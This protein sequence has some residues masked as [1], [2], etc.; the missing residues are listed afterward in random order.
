MAKI[1]KVFFRA[2]LPHFCLDKRDIWHGGG[3]CGAKNPF[4]DDWVNAIPAW[5]HCAQC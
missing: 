1:Q 4:L 3:A 2:V 5:L